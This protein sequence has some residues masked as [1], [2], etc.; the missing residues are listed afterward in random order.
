[1]PNWDTS[2]GGTKVIISPV[3]Y[4]AG[5]NITTSATYTWQRRNGGGAASALID[6]E[7]VVGN[8]LEITKNVLASATGGLITYVCTAH[9]TV[10][11]TVL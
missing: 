1:M 10:D 9:Y 7:E 6:G 4:Y 11:G 3:T 5:R 2:A 8:N